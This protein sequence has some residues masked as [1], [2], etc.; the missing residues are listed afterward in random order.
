[1]LNLAPFCSLSAQ[2]TGS[3]WAVCSGPAMLAKGLQERQA[4]TLSQ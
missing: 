1:M 3:K 4:L 2:P